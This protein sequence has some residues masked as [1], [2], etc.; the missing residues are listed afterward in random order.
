MTLSNYP[1]P[2][3]ADKLVP[4]KKPM[5]LVDRLIQVEDEDD[6]KSFSVVAATSPREGIFL[7]NN[8]VLPEYLVELM[9]QSVAAVDGYE[10]T[11]PEKRPTKGFLAS[12]DNF[13]CSGKIKPGVELR[14]EL[15]KGLSFGSI[16]LFTGSIYTNDTNRLLAQGQLKIWKEDGKS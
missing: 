8:R 15:I 12:I 3:R 14:V 4:H 7:E 13:S 10:N 2:C 16:F 1:L 9:A 5:L 6:P 11:R